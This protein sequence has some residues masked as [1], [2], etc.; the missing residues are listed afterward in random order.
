MIRT[1]DEK[2]AELFADISAVPEYFVRDSASWAKD[3]QETLVFARQLETIKRRMYEVKYPELKNRKFVPESNEAGESTEY[4]TFRIW[5]DYVMAKVYVN[6]MTDIPMVTASGSEVSVK[7]YSVVDGYQYSVDDLRSARAANLPLIDKL[8]KAVKTG[9]ELA[10]E[11]HVAFG[12]PEANSYGLLNHPNVTLITLP[13]GTW[14]GA[15]AEQILA[16]L[17]HLVTTMVDGTNEL[18]AGD[19]LVM[20]VAAKRLLET[21]LMSAGNSAGVSVLDMFRKQNDGIAIETWTLLNDANAAGTGPRILFYKR[22]PEVLEFEVA[23][24]FEQMPVEVRSL[25]YS[26]VCRAKWFGVQIQYPA[27]LSYADNAGV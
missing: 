26:V 18:F 27:A 22:S 17:N 3:A 9:I 12:T 25:T 2:A 23:I 5:Q 20:S 4:L 1:Y 19:T 7:P 15:T 8:A 13:T 14:S 6:Y 24:P 11:Q 10:R 21:K 16:D